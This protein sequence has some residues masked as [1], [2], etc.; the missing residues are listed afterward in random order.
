MRQMML[1]AVFVLSACATPAA[2]Q[3]TDHPAESC[4]AMDAALPAG[5]GD[6]NGKVAIGTAPSPEHAL[7]APLAPGKGYDASLAKK[8]EVVFSVEPQKPGGSVSYS[9]LFS[10]T[11]ETA[12]NYAVALGTE[13][14]ID[15]L[16]DGKALKPSKFGHGPECTTIRKMVTFAMKPG[17]HVLQVAGNGA[18]KLRVMVAKTS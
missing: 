5:L 3:R 18:D 6:W 15:V 2:A 16:E 9:G 4:A 17:V 1:I 14:W 12:G 7:H 13:A 8:A 11:V 10:F